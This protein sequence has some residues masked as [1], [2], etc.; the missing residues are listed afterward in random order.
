M[1]NIIDQFLNGCKNG[2]LEDVQYAFHPSSRDLNAQ[3]MT[4]AVNWGQWGIVRF[5]SPHVLENTHQSHSQVANWLTT[6]AREGYGEIVAHFLTQLPAEFHEIAVLAVFTQA[7]FHNHTHL[8]DVYYPQVDVKE[9]LNKMAE[10]EHTWWMLAGNG[11]EHVRERNEREEQHRAL[12]RSTTD[13]GK[14]PLARKL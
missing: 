10:Q 3:G 4:T 13:L 6:A 9:W 14:A 5:L 8:I 11:F 12:T 1:D 7:A 2:V